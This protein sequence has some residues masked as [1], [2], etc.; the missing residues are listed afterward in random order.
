[1]F[2][3]AQ[4]NLNALAKADVITVLLQETG[5][6][7]LLYGRDALKRVRNARRHAQRTGRPCKQ[8]RVLTVRIIVKNSD[9]MEELAYVVEMMKTY[10]C[11]N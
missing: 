6:D 9:E 5:V 8:E 10:A 2:K 4:F 7:Y 1:M 11:P 3:K